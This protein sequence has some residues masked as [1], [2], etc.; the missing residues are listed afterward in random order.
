MTAQQI[1]HLAKEIYKRGWEFNPKDF[2]FDDEH[3]ERKFLVK[4]QN[5]YAI[6]SNYEREKCYVIRAHHCGRT[7]VI[8]E[9]TDGTVIYYTEGSDYERVE[10]SNES[11]DLEAVLLAFQKYNDAA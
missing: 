7:L 9:H 2:C 8:G 6:I 4:C 11:Q 10:N 3:L 1:V 5:F